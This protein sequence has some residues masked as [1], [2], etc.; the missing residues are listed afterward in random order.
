MLNNKKLIHL[1]K[2]HTKIEFLDFNENGSLFTII[3]KF[4]SLEFIL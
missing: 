2:I 3:I 4:P 1:F